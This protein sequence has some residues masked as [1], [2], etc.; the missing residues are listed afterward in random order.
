MR[1]GNK[2]GLTSHAETH[3]SGRAS[4]PLGLQEQRGAVGCPERKKRGLCSGA[5]S[6]RDGV[7]QTRPPRGREERRRTP[8]SRSFP[9][10]G[11]SCWLNP[12]A[13]PSSQGVWVR[14]LLE[15]SSWG[16]E[17]GRGRRGCRGGHGRRTSMVLPQHHAGPAVGSYF[18]RFPNNITIDILSTWELIFVSQGAGSNNSGGEYRHLGFISSPLDKAG[19]SWPLG[20]DTGPISSSGF[21]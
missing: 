12:F 1:L 4:P 3:R 21:A 7:T 9:S 16:T 6:W 2:P 14:P 20:H 13:W 18:Q 17:R 11:S 15:V 5:V 8:P 19:V 10:Y